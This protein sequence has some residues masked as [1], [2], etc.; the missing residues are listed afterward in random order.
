MQLLWLQARSKTVAETLIHGHLEA[1]EQEHLV[2]Y[3]DGGETDPAERVAHRIGSRRQRALVVDG[4][5][6]TF[7]LDPR[8]GLTGPFLDLTRL[9]SSV[10]ACRAT[11]LQKVS[12]EMLKDT[13][14]AIYNHAFL[15]SRPTS[16][17]SL[18]NGL[19]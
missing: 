5:T 3:A 6:L 1:I 4:K 12:C 2:D 16:Y 10:L 17:V 13:S 7:I 11:P 18:R 19:V 15:L 9:C 14:N 8:S